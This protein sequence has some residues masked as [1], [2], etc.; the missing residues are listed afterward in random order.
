MTETQFT[1]YAAA[2]VALATLLGVVL[3]SRYNKKVFDEL[4]VDK[5]SKDYV[6]ILESRVKLLEHH[7]NECEDDRRVQTR[8]VNA[9]RD[10]NF[11]LMKRMV[12]NLIE[13]NKPKTPQS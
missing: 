6:V 5:A 2:I 7:V 8:A 11:N 12:E 10:E 13:N 4:K 3:K 1:A 9:L